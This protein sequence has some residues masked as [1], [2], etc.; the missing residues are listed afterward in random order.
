MSARSHPVH[1][2]V[3]VC[4]LGGVLCLGGREGEGA[5]ERHKESDSGMVRVSTHPPCVVVGM[6]GMGDFDNLGEVTGRKV[7]SLCAHSQ[8][9]H[10]SR[11]VKAPAN[12][13]LRTTTRSSP[14]PH[15]APIP[16]HCAH[17]GG[18]CVE[19]TVV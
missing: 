4:F 16:L 17:L 9:P 1:V 18:C 5:K 12:N 8:R 2:C 3:C 15:P 11:L 6:L 19:H 10:N 13:T 14:G 7:S